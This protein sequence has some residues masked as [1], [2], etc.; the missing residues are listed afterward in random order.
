MLGIC[1][2]LRA[3]CL[4]DRPTS[5]IKALKFSEPGYNNVDK[6]RQYWRT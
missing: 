1:G 4:T 6:W 3:G 2:A 5:S